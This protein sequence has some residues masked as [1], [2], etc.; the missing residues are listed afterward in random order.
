MKKIYFLIIG[1]CIAYIIYRFVIPEPLPQAVV[2]A[3]L[4]DAT[5][6]VNHVPSKICEQGLRYLWQFFRI[7]G[8]K[9]TFSKAAHS[10]GGLVLMPALINGK[11]D[12]V[13]FQVGA[14]FR[15]K[16]IILSDEAIDLR[17]FETVLRS[18]RDA[19]KK[20]REEAAEKGWL[21]SPGATGDDG[22]AGVLP[23][24]LTE[25]IEP[26]E[27]LASLELVSGR[28]DVNPYDSRLWFAAGSYIQRLQ[29]SSQSLSTFWYN[30]NSRA[31]A[32]W[33]IGAGLK[34]LSGETKLVEASLLYRSQNNRDAYP[35]AAEAS[36]ALPH[37][38]FAQLLPVLIRGDSRAMRE[39]GKRKDLSPYL[40]VELISALSYAKMNKSAYTLLRNSE[41]RWPGLSIW[42]FMASWYGSVGPARRATSQLINHIP[43]EVIE[44]L[45]S[46]DRDF[47]SP[48]VRKKNQPALEAIKKQSGAGPGQSGSRDPFQN[49]DRALSLIA[50]VRA[51]LSS[52]KAPVLPRIVSPR[53]TLRILQ[54]WLR[55]A[56]LERFEVLHKKLGVLRTA[57][58]FLAGLEERFPDSLEVVL[59]RDRNCYRTGDR[60][61]ERAA[62]E[63][64]LSSSGNE[65]I[66]G[67]WNKLLLWA[68]GGK[69]ARGRILARLTRYFRYFPSGR[70]SIGVC[71]YRLGDQK[72][73]K[74]LL[75]ETLELDPYDTDIRLYIAYGLKDPQEVKAL[76]REGEG[77]LPDSY[78]FYKRLGTYY[79]KQ[80]DHERAIKYFLR[81]VEIYPESPGARKCLA[82]LYFDS[83]QTDKAIAQ[84]Q[85]YLKYDTESLTAIA[86]RNRIGN[87]YLKQEKYGKAYD[88]YKKTAGSWKAS[89]LV[90]MA[91]ACK[92]LERY[93]EAE[94]W[95]RRAEQRYPYDWCVIALARFY[96]DRGRY[97]DG[98]ELLMKY[99]GQ[100]MNQKLRTGI[101]KFYLD[102]AEQPAKALA[103]FKKI[104]A[105]DLS[106]Q[107]AWSMAVIHEA[108]DD[109][110][111]AVACWEN[112]VKLNRKMGSAQWEE[113]AEEK[114]KTARKLYQE[115]ESAMR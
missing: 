96:Y 19:L 27:L 91:R 9:I 47:V 13:R 105:G 84:L 74:E 68:A 46:P 2:I 10:P 70:G 57:G 95:F 94:K 75:R 8:M 35:L 64:I 15:G 112:C 93:E 92:G 61:G 59:G 29:L 20:T 25:T 90:G 98:D 106:P 62:A 11:K 79:S 58:E 26:G 16:K 81:A 97:K 33:A 55:S 7:P 38:L 28:L 30:L 76:F 4:R 104:P 101:R 5:G 50:E 1:I 18:V 114:L 21:R 88:I 99:A 80:E 86:M 40:A 53:D 100:D 42:D 52:D 23:D 89:S 66:L 54:V 65:F 67:Y 6:E 82:D 17:T 69:A 78:N 45:L 110:E 63:K 44:F 14:T 37:S 48:A 72:R 12:E 49:L 39:W 56:F 34:P 31:G 103:I 113:R 3:P 36:K 87:I 107:D 83:E 111:G 108:L 32:L 24:S 41:K 60:S 71:Y 43:G 22:S 115:Q 102:E 77:I 51:A 109:Y 85:D 73:S